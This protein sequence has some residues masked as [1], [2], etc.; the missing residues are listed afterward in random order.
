LMSASKSILS[1]NNL[2]I[3]RSKVTKKSYEF[4]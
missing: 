3:L 2:N 4:S 1:L